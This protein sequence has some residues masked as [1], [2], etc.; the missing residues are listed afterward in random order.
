MDKNMRSDKIFI[1]FPWVELI[2]FAF[3]ILAV[4]YSTTPS[5]VLNG[6]GLQEIGALSIP[7]AAIAGTTMATIGF[8]MLSK[9]HGWRKTSTLVLC[10]INAAVFVFLIF[11]T[12][13]FLVLI[14]RGV[15][16]V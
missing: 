5:N 6:S 9:L 16:V 4:L 8:L 3:Y 7:V 11:G 12:M 15:L 1:L 10:I 14:L 2:P 13:F